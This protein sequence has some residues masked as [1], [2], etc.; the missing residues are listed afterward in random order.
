MNPAKKRLV[1]ILRFIAVI[2]IL[3]LILVVLVFH[4][5][6][7][8]SF[9]RGEYP[10]YPV[11]NYRYDHYQ[12]RYPRVSIS[13]SSG[14]NRLQGFLYGDKESDRLLVFCHGLGS[15]H[16]DYMNEIIYMTD[17]GYRVLAY[18]ETGSGMSEGKTS[19]G[20]LQ[21]ALDLDAAFDYIESSDDLK[22]L[23]VYLMGH[24]WG[25]FAVAETLGRHDIVASVP[26][27]AYAYPVDLLIDQGSKMVEE[28]LS[29][30]KFFFH[31]SQLITYGPENFKRNAVDSINS[32]DTPILLVHGNKDQMIPLETISII[33]HK[34]KLTNPNVQTLILTKEEQN[35]HNNILHSADSLSHRKALN[36][37]FAAKMDSVKDLPKDVQE[38]RAFQFRKEMVEAADLPL[39]NQVNEDL[40]KQILQFYD[41][42][43]P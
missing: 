9:S 35:N 40:F 19:V 11:I 30:M 6:I 33:A 28:D 31:L 43:S 8:S 3:G 37:A 42:A 18:D 15:G 4:Y 24:S 26:I 23:P 38:E 32:T 41:Q 22:D 2:P 27:A 34:D 21:S 5:I 7:T 29:G 36:D 12:D 1:K 39:V 14:K 17:A 20:V 10:P 13:F 16:E 25:G